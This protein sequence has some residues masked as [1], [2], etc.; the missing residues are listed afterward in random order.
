MSTHNLW[1]GGEVETLESAKLP[2][3]GSIPLQ[4]SEKIGCTVPFRSFSEGGNPARISKRGFGFQTKF[5]AGVEDST[6]HS[7]LMDEIHTQQQWDDLFLDEVGKAIVKKGTVA[8]IGEDDSADE[9]TGQPGQL[10]RNA[11]R[12]H[13][14]YSHRRTILSEAMQPF[15][16]KDPPPIA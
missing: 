4:A 6:S 12:T 2:C 1:L 11:M 14:L 9:I 3:R 16:H 5:E 10:V 8:P 7:G 13:L 15:S